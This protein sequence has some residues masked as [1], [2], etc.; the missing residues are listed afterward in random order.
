MAY[1][2]HP[3]EA[4]IAQAYAAGVLI[5]QI[6]HQFCCGRVAVYN[7]IRRNG[8]HPRRRLLKPVVVA[9]RLAGKSRSEIKE[10]TGLTARQ[11]GSACRHHGV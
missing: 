3:K 5:K 8:I 11:I 6:I 9:L 2:P 7:A 4:E 10:V 1:P